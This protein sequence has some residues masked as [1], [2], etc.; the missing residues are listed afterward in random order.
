MERCQIRGKE[1]NE[2]EKKSDC[3]KLV[4]KCHD[5]IETRIDGILG[6]RRI[7]L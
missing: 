4:E 2:K 6:S 5:M 3:E 1:K 7:G